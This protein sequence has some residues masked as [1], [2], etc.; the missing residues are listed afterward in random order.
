MVAGNTVTAPGFYAPQGRELRVPIRYP[1]LLEQLNYYHNNAY[2]FWLTNFEMES[3]GYYAMGRLLGHEMLSVNAILANR[4]TNEFTNHPS[5]IMDALISKV[6][7]R[8]AS[9]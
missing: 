4:I 9:L 1:K 5:K 2:N 6:L 7:E 8:V 3:A